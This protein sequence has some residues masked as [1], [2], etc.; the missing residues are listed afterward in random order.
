LLPP[1]YPYTTLFRSC[2]D[3]A[4]G[5]REEADGQRRERGEQA[6]QLALEREEL[7]VE[8]EG[9][10]RAVEVEVV[11]LDR[12]PHERG[13]E[14]PFLAADRVDRKSTRLNSSHVS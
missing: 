10:G 4:Q 7:D 9:R 6:A 13:R 11:P 2:D 12:R 1:R 3:A 5:S 8:D 14:D